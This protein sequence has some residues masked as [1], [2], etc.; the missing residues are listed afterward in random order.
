MANL[1]PALVRFFL[2][3]QNSLVTRKPRAHHYEDVTHLHTILYSRGKSIIDT[4]PHI[5]GPAPNTPEE[6]RRDFL[7]LR[8][9]MNSDNLADWQG[10]QEEAE[11][12]LE[13]ERVTEA[14][15]AAGVDV[16]ANIQ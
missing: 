14:A 4:L 15:K 11:A 16:E 9:A 8:H 13:L 7:V 1:K 10:K 5:K 2:T 12:E 3:C 6:C